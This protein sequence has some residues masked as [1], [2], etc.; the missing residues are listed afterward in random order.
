MAPCAAFASSRALQG[1]LGQSSVHGQ[2]LCPS[3]AAPCRRR[4]AG[5]GRVYAAG[6]GDVGSYLA[7]AAKQVFSPTKSNAPPNWSG[8]G[9]GFSGKVSHHDTQKLRDLYTLLRQARV[10][11]QGCMD[12]SA[13]N[14]DPQATA[15]DG[16]CSFIAEDGQEIKGTVPEIGNYVSNMLS[17]VWGSA[18]ITEDSKNAFKG[19]GYPFSGDIVSRRDIERLVRYE[20]IVKKELE[21]VEQEK[22]TV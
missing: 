17:K 16:T 15:D 10:G 20:K 13:E 8:T 22:T 18:N 6:L 9:S 12:P 3:A 11:I 7:D 21:K 4:L 19:S 1:S 14:F 2:R 5:T